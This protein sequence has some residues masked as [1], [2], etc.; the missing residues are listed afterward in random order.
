[1]ILINLIAKVRVKIFI[2]NSSVRLKFRKGSGEKKLEKLGKIISKWQPNLLN[3]QNLYGRKNHYK[4][5][6]TKTQG[7][8]NKSKMKFFLW[9]LALKTN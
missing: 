6:I 4:I 3:Q 8:C 2:V 5:F 9:V 7:K 1:M